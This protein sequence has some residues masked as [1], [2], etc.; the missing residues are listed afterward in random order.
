LSQAIGNLLHNCAKFTSAGGS[1]S[2]T[3]STNEKNAFIKV[4]DSGVGMSSELIEQMFQPF[5]QGEA[6]LDRSKG[7]LG[8]GL[9]LCKRLIELHQGTISAHSDGVGHG[10]EFHISLPLVDAPQ[11]TEKKISKNSEIVQRRVLIIEDN[12]DSADTLGA[13]LEISG[14][15]VSITYTGPNGIDRAREFMPDVVVCDIGLPDLNGY[16]VARKFKADEDLNRI[17]LVALSGYAMPEDLKRASEA[18]FDHY[19]KKP[20]DIKK[21]EE[22]LGN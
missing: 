21:L 20:A 14:H 12:E 17:T 10:A 4:K 11:R 16:E 9:A 5:I 1:T 18:G 13:L 8:L 6:T 15:N 3:V 19:L 7:G 22:I 2:I